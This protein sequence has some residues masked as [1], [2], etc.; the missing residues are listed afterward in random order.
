MAEEK[1]KAAAKNAPPDDNDAADEVENT[2]TALKQCKESYWRTFDVIGV[3]VGQI[4]EDH[5]IDEVVDRNRTGREFLVAEKG[6]AVFVC[7]N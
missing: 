7:M 3:V 2:T 4:A 1:A 6:S 5:T